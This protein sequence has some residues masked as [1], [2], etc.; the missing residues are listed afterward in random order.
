VKPLQALADDLANGRVTSRAL[1]ESCLDRIA[2]P[3]GE[4]K[5]AFIQVDADGA[6]AAADAVDAQRKRGIAPTPF[7]GIPISIKDLFDIQ[8]QVTRAGSTI[9]ADAP[10]AM[11]DAP[12]VARLRA[13]GFVIVG[14]TNMT[15]FA[16]SG[17]GINPHYGTPLNPYDRKTG[18]VPGGSTAGGAVSVTDDMAAVALGT[19]TG[20]SCRIPPAFTGLV[21]FKPTARRV[22]LDGTVPL[23]TSLDSVGP[24]GRTV[25][26][27]AA[28]DAI[29][30]CE[31][32]AA[33]VPQAQPVKGLRLAV[34]QSFVL[35]DVDPA[36]MAAFEA[37]LAALRKAGAVIDELP[38]KELLELPKINGKGGLAAAESYAWHRRFLD[39]RADDYDPRVRSR[40]VKGKEQDAADYIDLRA[41]R[42]DL[43]TRVA[44]LTAPY[45]AVA[46]PTVAILAPTVAEL[47][48]DAAFTRANML[49]LRNTAV[50]N[51]LDGCAI[52]LPAHR[53]GE[54]PV[55]FMLMGAHG[56]DERLLS[57]AACVAERL[58]A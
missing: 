38:L 23:S 37:A 46:M 3:T 18:R 20:G 17:I 7:A 36:V 34:P 31:R 12:A 51:F 41:A 4:G 39:A 47:A 28:V 56:A 58:P 27:C 11:Q 53:A 26:C 30:S 49:A 24:L 43:I 52:S 33:P 16:F 10:P 55:G 21:G 35:D 45:D 32:A 42:A 13:A 54:A 2:D 15:E 44:K 9:L 48:N 6:R 25:A 14:R 8:G 5:R 40:I 29:V 50:A 22:P 19:D 1:V 57:I